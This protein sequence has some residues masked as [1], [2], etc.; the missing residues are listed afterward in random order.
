MSVKIGDTEIK[1]IKLGDTDIKI[2][3]LGDDMVYPNAIDRL[4]KGSGDSNGYYFSPRLY[5]TDDLTM[6]Y[7]VRIPSTNTWIGGVGATAWGEST[8]KMR[9]GPIVLEGS[10]GQQTRIINL[11]AYGYKEGD[12]VVI[13]IN[14]DG[15]SIDNI[16]NKFDEQ[17]LLDS[18]YDIQVLRTPG[19]T[20]DSIIEVSRV[21]F[22]KGDKKI[23]NLVPIIDKNGKV[24]LFN[25]I[26]GYKI[27]STGAYEDRI[28]GW[29][30]NGELVISPIVR[31]LNLE[32]H[33]LDLQSAINV[34]DA[35]QEVTT[36][37]TITF[38]SATSALITE[39]DTAME[40]VMSAM[41][42]GWNIVL[43]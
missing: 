14:K 35:L 17:S 24:N 16:T 2:V 8:I 30:K 5:R 15:L 40:K 31:S 27:Y 39:D 23:I 10:Y 18:I 3:M 22:Y 43:N 12:K 9:I 42:I 7:E 13:K 19:T 25:T 34:L 6:E 36:P 29:K 41:E 1:A 11:S 21:T 20:N 33:K 4:T 38:S 37:Q 28:F 32:C 26:D